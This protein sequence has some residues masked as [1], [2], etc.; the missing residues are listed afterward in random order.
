MFTEWSQKCLIKCRIKSFNF[1]RQDITYVGTKK[2]GRLTS[3]TQ[4]FSHIIHNHLTFP[5]IGNSTEP[6][7]SAAQCTNPDPKSAV[8]MPQNAASITTLMR[9]IRKCLIISTKFNS[10]NVMAA[11]THIISWARFPANGH[12]I[13]Y[14]PTDGMEWNYSVL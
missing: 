1:K 7:V 5:I 8:I 3:D 4:S 10:I 12:K 6:Q 14:Q 2:K 9:S 11:Y 13:T